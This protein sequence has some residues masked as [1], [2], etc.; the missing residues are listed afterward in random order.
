MCFRHIP[1]DWTGSASALDALQEEVRRKLIEAGAFY[2][3]Q[4]Q[5]RRHMYLRVTLINPL[6]TEQGLYALLKAVRAAAR[7][8][9]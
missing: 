7:E 6:T 2:L 8:L 3:V 4:T 5:L 1:E 9:A